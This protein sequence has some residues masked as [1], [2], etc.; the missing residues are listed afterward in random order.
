MATLAYFVTVTIVI[1]MIFTWSQKTLSREIS[2]SVADIYHGQFISLRQ[3]GR[4]AFPVF[5]ANTWNNL[6]PHVISAL[7]LAVF[8]WRLRTFIFSRSYPDV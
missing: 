3:V 4:R 1:I 6:P 8:R 2:F 7:S 5:G